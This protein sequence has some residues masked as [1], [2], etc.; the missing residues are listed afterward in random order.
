MFKTEGADWKLGTSD[1]KMLLGCS[2]GELMLTHLRWRERQ[3]QL[4]VED[5]ASGDGCWV[6]DSLGHGGEAG[7]LAVDH[8]ADVFSLQLPRR[9]AEPH[10]VPQDDQVPLTLV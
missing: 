9:V 1:C 3:R 8:Q 10:V 7:R 6:A 5:H 2:R 4:T